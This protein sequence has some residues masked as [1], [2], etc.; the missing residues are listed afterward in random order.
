MKKI[1]IWAIAILG[2][3]LSVAPFAYAQVTQPAEQITITTTNELFCAIDQ[4]FDFLF[5]LLIAFSVIMII[6]A[7][8]NYLTAQDN[9]EK[10]TKAT[11]TL[12]YVAVGVAV[13]LIAK[14]F[15]I[16]IGDIFSASI[17]SQTQGCSY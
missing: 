4:L 13:A 11:K 9:A 14:G 17:T 12:T 16:L 5:Y 6:V 10:V 2:I 15:P 3:S 8:Y 7:A 1:K